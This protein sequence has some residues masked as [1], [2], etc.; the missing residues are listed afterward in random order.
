[1]INNSLTGN[2]AIKDVNVLTSN[3][4][5]DVVQSILC[6]ALTFVLKGALKLTQLQKVRYLKYD[7][8]YQMIILLHNKYKISVEESAEYNVL[9]VM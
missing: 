4:V 5:R 1:M 8:N 9:F 2:V 3:S 6:L 7:C